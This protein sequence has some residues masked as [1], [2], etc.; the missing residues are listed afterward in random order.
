MRWDRA[1]MLADGQVSRKESAVKQRLT[2]EYWIILSILTE[3]GH[4]RSKAYFG[5][6]SGHISRMVLTTCKQHSSVNKYRLPIID[7]CQKIA[8]VTPRIYPRG[9]GNSLSL[10]KNDN[11]IKNELYYKNDTLN[12]SKFPSW[13][14]ATMFSFVPLSHPYL[15]LPPLLRLE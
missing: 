14:Q 4:M 15:P 9:E 6:C 1:N 13:G 7:L 3:N 5:F 2:S 8:D 12:T 10:S 11:K